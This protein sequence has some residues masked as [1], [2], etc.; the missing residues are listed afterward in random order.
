MS[1][2]AL[3]LQQL[4]KN[5]AKVIH[6]Q[7]QSLLFT[8]TT[9]L[10]RGH[11]LIEDVPGL[12]KTTLARALAKSVQVDMRRLQ[13]TP[14]VMPSDIT[15][16]SVFNPQD[17]S[18][19]L[20]PGPIFTNLLLVDEINRATPRT[21]SA[22]LEAMA[23]GTVSIDRE[24][25]ALP[26]VFMVIATQN[27]VEFS[28]TYPLPEAQL[29]RFFMRI[30]LGYPSE[31]QELG[32]LQAQLS[33][34]PL[35]T[36]E[37]VMSDKALQALQAHCEKIPLS[38]ALLGYINQL[39]RA[40]REHP[41]VQL[42][43]SPRGALALMRAARAMTLLTGKKQVTPH[44]VQLLVDPVL[45]H[46]LIFRNPGMNQAE[47]RQAFWD[48]LLAQIPVPDFARTPQTQAPAA[49]SSSDQTRE[50][51]SKTTQDTNTNTPRG[52]VKARP[53]SESR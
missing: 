22:L 49:E 41:K 16:V 33:G 43:A 23:E 46:R 37:A 26:A 20:S 7:P 21:Q 39:V 3:S 12:G 47:Q 25:H 32:I 45:S 17:Q 4:H 35:D 8:L 31:E 9:L 53:G 1:N 27:P 10:C 15:G 2:P 50:T 51:E 6:C 44:T 14:D 18:F 34:H 42:G 11:L 30:S 28:G 13:C 19:H 5:L 48:D 29:D 24:I 36:L 38:E 52:R 40:T